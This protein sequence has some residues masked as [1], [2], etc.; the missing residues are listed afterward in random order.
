[1]TLQQDISA[2]LD[3]LTAYKVVPASEAQTGLG[4]P[5]YPVIVRF[6]GFASNPQRAVVETM[7]VLGRTGQSLVS[8]GVGLEDV[9]GRL[10]SDIED[11]PTTYPRIRDANVLWEQDLS[12]L[13]PNRTASTGQAGRQITARHVVGIVS[14]LGPPEF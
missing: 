9:F 12:T 5:P 7:I 13:A 4:Y 11:V 2:H 6:A 3:S 14:V 10:I 8:D 1:M